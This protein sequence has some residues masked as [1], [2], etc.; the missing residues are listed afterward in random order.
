ML[1]DLLDRF[2]D[3]GINLLAALIGAGAAVLVGVWRR[4]RRTSDVRRFWGAPRHPLTFLLP[5]W[6]RTPDGWRSAGILGTG[7]VRALLALQRTMGALRRGFEVK[8]APTLRDASSAPALVLIGGPRANT[9]SASILEELG[10]QVLYSFAPDDGSII[11]PGRRRSGHEMDDEDNGTDA[12]LVLRVENPYYS[13]GTVY[14]LAGVSG[15]GTHAAARLVT[16]DVGRLLGRLRQDGVDEGG[17]FQLL[18]TVKIVNGTP[19]EPRCVEAFPLRL[20][21]RASAPGG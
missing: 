11:G 7:D 20:P 10:G 3:L 21:D 9:W 18:L 5:I 19:Q 13:A 4:R 12:A 16:T 2:V 15:V 6:D 1:A 8:E 14:V 17:G